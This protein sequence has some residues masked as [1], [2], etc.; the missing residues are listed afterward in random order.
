M[1]Q[2]FI[3][4]GTYRFL[5]GQIHFEDHWKGWA[6]KIKTLLGP[7]MTTSDGFAR[8]KIIKSRSHITKTCTLVFYVYEFCSYSIVYSV[9]CILYSL[10][11]ILYSV[12]S[13]LYS[14]FSILWVLCTS[15]GTN[16]L[17]GIFESAHCKCWFYK[18]Q[19]CGT[20]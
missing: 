8:I 16:S 15:K 12:F 13:I 3:R 2:L 1:Y 17:S 19:I 6:L 5:C 18:I 4:R 10:F 20:G 11:P 7:E 14:L 9:F